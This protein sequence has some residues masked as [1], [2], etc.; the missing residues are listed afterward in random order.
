MRYTNIR[1]PRDVQA[2]IL[3]HKY[4]AA[5]TE[6]LKPARKQ[7]RMDGVNAGKQ[8]SW[9]LVEKKTKDNADIIVRGMTDMKPQFN[10]ESGMTLV[11]LTLAA[12][13]LAVALSMLF[14]SLVTV[15]AM[16]RI[17][18]SRS[19]AES[20]LV[21]VMEELETIKSLSG[22]LEYEPPVPE[23]LG[24]LQTLVVE[25]VQ[26]DGTRI[27]LPVES[28]A[29]GGTPSIPNPAQVECTVSWYCERR[30]MS[31]KATKMFRR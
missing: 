14:G 2:R 30:P 21:G 3:L 23:S 8:L 1:D 7:F 16:G 10:K 4:R 17:T 12:G 15:T 24:P 19:I 22:L 11:E 20:D 31:I 25:V 28:G 18:E 13:I 27:P 9:N 5:A 6:P 26:E 29:A